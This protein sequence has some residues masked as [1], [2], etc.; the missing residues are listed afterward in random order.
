VVWRG[1]IKTGATVNCS[2][3]KHVDNEKRERETGAAKSC[4]LSGATFLTLCV[5][6]VEATHHII[7]TTTTQRRRGRGWWAHCCCCS[8]RKCRRLTGHFKSFAWP[9]PSTRTEDRTGGARPPPA[10]AVGVGV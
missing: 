1:A 6:Y 4:C 2:A 8:Q 3:G 10:G 9:A 5:D 7:I